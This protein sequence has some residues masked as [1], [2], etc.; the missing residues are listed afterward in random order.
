MESEGLTVA[1]GVS[2]EFPEES[3]VTQGSLLES[4]LQQ[5]LERV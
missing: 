4:Q 5:G 2:M 3:E 1:V